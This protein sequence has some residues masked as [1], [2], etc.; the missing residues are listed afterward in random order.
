MN[1]GL[2]TNNERYVNIIII[3]HQQISTI[4]KITLINEANNSTTANNLLYLGAPALTSR[5]FEEADFEKVV[6]YIDQGVQIA[7]EAKTRAPSWF[8]S[9]FLFLKLLVMLK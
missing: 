5:S 6:D 2:F 1:L 9:F 8:C 3:I 4:Y 7:V